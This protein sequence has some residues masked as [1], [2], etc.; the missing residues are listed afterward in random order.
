MKLTKYTLLIVAALFLSIHGFAV[1]H[2]VHVGS[3]YFTPSTLNVSVGDTIRWVWDGGSHTTTSS[4]IP[5]GAATWDSP[6]TS[7]VQSFEYAVTK[8]GVHNYVCTPHASMGQVGSFT[9]AGA[10]PTLS[11]SPSNRNVPASNGTTSFTVTSNSTWSATSSASWCAV[12]SGGSGNGTIFADYTENTSLTS[13]TAT[14]TVSVSGLPNQTVTVTQAGA[15]PTLSVSPANQHVTASSG[16]TGFSILSNTSWIAV[17]DAG[18][19]TVTSNGSGNGTLTATFTE[20]TTFQVRTATI[21]VTVSGLTPTTVTV[22]QD[23]STVGLGENTRYQTVVMPN[24]STGIFQIRTKEK[25]FGVAG[26]TVTDL[27]GRT[28][29]TGDWDSGNTL[30]L[31]LTGNPAGIYFLSIKSDH[32]ITVKRLIIMDQGTGR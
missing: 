14:I 18:W 5:A 16:T 26:Y 31:D 1:K 27:T 23:A 29:Q 13:R 21:T 20:N 7:A 10:A 25:A 8:T 11:V 12:T 24:P 22:T 28:L 6:M 3:F 30:R 2:I 9:A 4:T 15:A 19:C 32:T 17:S